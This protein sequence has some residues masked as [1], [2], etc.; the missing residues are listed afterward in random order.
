MKISPLSSSTGQAGQNLGSVDVGRTASPVKLERARAIARGETVPEVPEEQSEV[1]KPNVRSIRMRT[2]QSTN[3]EEPLEQAVNAIQSQSPTNSSELTPESSNPESTEAGSVEATKQLSPQFAAL[4]KQKRSLQLEREAFA[5]EKAAVEAL[6]EGHVAVSDL[7]ANPLKL[8]ELG[9]TYE[10]LT[11][12]IVDQQNGINPDIEA[13]KQELKA[14]KEG[15]DKTFQTKEEQAEEAALT[16]MLYEAE[17]LAK[18][19]D[20]FE[21]IREQKAFDRVLRHIHG[22][23]KKTGRVLS[24]QEAMEKIETDLLAEAEKFASYNK[25]R[26]KLAPPPVPP[27]QPQQKQMRTLTARDNA[28]PAL[29]RR[30]RAIATFNGTMKR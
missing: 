16:E 12:A 11:K 1:S 7:K 3:R 15:V 2:Q 27:L 21:L 13:M 23:Y 29:S 6:K 14:L 25:V 17:D 22:T 24:V 26:S 4:A 9:I 20:A 5:K 18:E 28:T 30:A 8:F 10:E 19:G